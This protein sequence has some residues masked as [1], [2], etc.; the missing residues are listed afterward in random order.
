MACGHLQHLVDAGLVRRDENR[1]T[2]YFA[3]PTWRGLR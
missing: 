2:R 3:E 1:P